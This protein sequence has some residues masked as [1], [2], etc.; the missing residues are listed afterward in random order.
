MKWVLGQLDLGRAV[1][2]HPFATIGF[3]SAAEDPKAIYLQL[4][5]TF[6]L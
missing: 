4:S 2:C 1:N 6:V 3:N 5:D